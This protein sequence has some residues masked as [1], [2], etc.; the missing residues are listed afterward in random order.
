M[1]SRDWAVIRKILRGTSSYNKEVYEHFKNDDSASSLTTQR[2]FVR[3][4]CLIQAKDSAGMAQT[5]MRFFREQVQKTHIKPAIIGIPKEEFDQRIGYEYKPMVTL[6]FQQDKNSVP[7]S[8]APV[9][10]EI[11]FRLMDKTEQTLTQANITTLATAI[12]NNFATGQG[13]TF[14]KGKIIASYIDRQ[15]GYHLQL[16]VTTLTEGEQVVKKILGIQNHI[17][18]SDNFRHTEPKKNTINNPGKT[19]VAGKTYRKPRWRPTATVRFQWAYLTFHSSP[20]PI[21]LV[22]RTFTRPKPAIGV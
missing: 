19:V 2:L 12:K 22:D 10:A 7:T 11:S 18:Q 20:D 3:N 8:F 17:Y 5:R 1:A 15:N 21:Y 16:Y 6:Y 9:T 13:Y 4:A 14:N